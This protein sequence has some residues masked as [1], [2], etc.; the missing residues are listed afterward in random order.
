M[1]LATVENVQD[2]LKLL[3]RVL[4][5]DE[6]V[7]VQEW[8]DDVEADVLAR[9]ADIL[10]DDAVRLR[11]L[12]RVECEVVIAAINNPFGPLRRVM[13]TVDD[14]TESREYAAARGSAG[15]LSI[16][17]EQWARLVPAGLVSSAAFTISP[18][19]VA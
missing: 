10:A 15:S 17:D 5:D 12:V 1:A 4:T 7:T 18:S 11:Q 9:Y 6:M 14:Y 8:L 16:T 13:T 2:R 19:Y 3:G